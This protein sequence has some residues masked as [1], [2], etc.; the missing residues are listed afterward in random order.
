MMVLK[1]LA[2]AADD[3]MN[4]SQRRR[5]G[6]R[7]IEE[8]AAGCE[9]CKMHWN[10]RLDGKK[11]AELEG[12]NTAYDKA[13]SKLENLKEVGGGRTRAKRRRP[14]RTGTKKKKRTK[15]Q[16]KKGRKTKKH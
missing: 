14:K 3:D 10:R 7:G 13:K 5:R 12:F 2:V 9:G 11:G 15:R 16:K 1:L 8:G 4:W 6:Q